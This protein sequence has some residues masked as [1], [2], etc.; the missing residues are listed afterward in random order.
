MSIQYCVAAT[1]ARGAIE[2]SNYH[3]LDDPEINRLVS[4][5]KLEIDRR[6]HCRISGRAGHGSD[7][8]VAARN[9]AV[10]DGRCGPGHAGSDSRAIPIGVRELREAIEDMIDKLERAGRRRRLRRSWQREEASDVDWREVGRSRLGRMVRIGESVHGETVGVGSARL[11]SRC[12]SGHR[13]RQVRVSWR[14]AQA[15][16]HRARR[17]APQTRRPGGGRSR[18]GW[19]RSNPPTTAS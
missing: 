4:V 18:S 8:E 12:G 6:V 2:E 17:A 19:R 15:D 5:T 13:R 10:S 1:L 14:M 3:V 7:C 16:R 11:Q 9:R